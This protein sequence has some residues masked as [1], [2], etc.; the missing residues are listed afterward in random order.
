MK[1]III[2]ILIIV[3]LVFI[4]MFFLNPGNNEKNPGMAAGKNSTTFTPVNIYVAKK[5]QLTNKLFVTGTIIANEE[6][7][8]MPEISGKIVKLNINEGDEV[9]KDELLVKINDADLQAQLKKSELQ[10]KLAEDKVNRQKQLLTIS[11]ISQEEFD[12]A[13][14]QLNTLKADIEYT[15]AQIAKTEIRAPFNGIIGLKNVSEGSFVSPTTRIASIQQLDQVKVDFSIP[16]KYTE[17]INKNAIINFSVANSDKKYTAK[18]YAIE[19]KIDMAMRTVQVRAISDNKNKALFPGATAKIEVPL[20][21]INDAIVIPTE[22]IIPILKGQKV[23]VCKNGKANEVVVETG[24]R[25]DSGIQII[26]G[27]AAGD[28][29]ITTGIMQL[30]NNAPVKPLATGNPKN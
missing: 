14:N 5:E 13:L 4:K 17:S 11:G 6:I 27:I 7:T 23:F 9:K 2:I 21:E 8:L 16:E 30:K 22:A 3:L 15:K 28:S 29:V 26:S 18:V 19:P 20:K 12:I 24:I 10:V 1:K 25:T